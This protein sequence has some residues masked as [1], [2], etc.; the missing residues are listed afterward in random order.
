MS[1][2][3]MNGRK[4]RSF[5]VLDDYNREALHIEVDYS[6]KSNRVV[7]VLNHLI[8]RR[9]KPKRI[10]MDNGPEF[11]TTLMAEWSQMQEIEFIFIQPGK[12]TQNAFV[13]RFNGTFRRHVLDAYLLDNL[14]EVR[15]ITSTWLEDY[16]YK[17]PHDA[18][19]GLSPIEF[20]KKKQREQLLST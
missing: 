14:Q 17:R 1:D 4:F 8:Q 5:H 16:N 20:A 9:E 18:L 7:W 15:E 2:A 12:P 3:L 10:R 6:L 19:G 13:E 11:V